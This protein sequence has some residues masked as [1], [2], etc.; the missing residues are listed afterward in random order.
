MQWVCF[1][2]GGVVERRW[3]RDIL[4]HFGTLAALASRPSP[5]PSPTGDAPIARMRGLARAGEGVALLVRMGPLLKGARCASVTRAAQRMAILVEIRGI[6][7]DFDGRERC[8]ARVT[9]AH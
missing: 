7:L 6:N 2:P 1:A 9:G 4:G 5:P 8:A 3:K